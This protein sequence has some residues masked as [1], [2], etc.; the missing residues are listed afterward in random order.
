MDGRKTCR[1]RWPRVKEVTL[2]ANFCTSSIPDQS[3]AM[4]PTGPWPATPFQA[5]SHLPLL[6]LPSVASFAALPLLYENY[7]GVP[8]PDN[9]TPLLLL[10]LAKRVTI[11]GE[12]VEW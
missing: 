7:Q 1:T 10:L 8:P 3:T 9:L 4:R 11:Y 12:V 2:P 5:A 6:A